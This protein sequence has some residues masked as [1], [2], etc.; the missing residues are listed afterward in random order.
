[1][2]QITIRIDEELL[3]A[4]DVKAQRRGISR[5]DYIRIAITEKIER[6]TA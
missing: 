4:I 5:A 2:K 1:M 3:T 6:D